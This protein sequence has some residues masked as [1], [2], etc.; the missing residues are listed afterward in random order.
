L[1]ADHVEEAGMA[2]TQ[3]A[4]LV[5]SGEGQTE[6]ILRAPG[7]WESRGVGN[8][9]L[10]TTT[11][12]DVIV[13]PGMLHDGERGRELFARVSQSPVR[14]IVLTQSHANQC[15]A[16]ELF[17]TDD[18]TLIAHREWPEGRAYASRLRQYYG[19]RSAKLWGS[20]TRMGSGKPPRD[21]PP[22][23]LIDDRFA[24]EL[25]GRRFEVI[26][27]PGGETRDA[28]V[29]WMPD[30][31]I[32]IVGNLFGPIFG[33]QPNLNTVRGDKPRWALQYI[34]SAKILRDLGADLVLTGHEAIEG[35]D[36]IRAGIT[37]LIESTQ[38]LHDRT[39]EGMN[40]GKDL[41][42]LMRE[43]RPPP[44]LVLGEGHGKVS[45]NVRAIWAEY[46]GWFDY[47]YTTSLYETP[48]SSVSGDLVALAG[49]AGPL[50]ARAKARLAAG[51]PVEAM[52]L[53]EVALEAEPANADAKAVKRDVLQ[54]LLD[55]AGGVN[56]SETMWLRS[57]L[58]A[59]DA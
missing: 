52:H 33:H 58:A 18:N 13:N 40:A 30:E 26:S 5:K 17:K 34:E 22:E 24:F 39:I 49:G 32:V 47:D 48:R 46:T 42:T 51:E 53:L 4:G 8:S 11:A 31:K 25:G 10:I 43:V 35:A 38:W 50:A 19:R 15:D 57:E 29:L 6:A 27:T 2:G 55:R 16:V 3:L 12:G 44:E 1:I 37:R 54:V 28:T 9:Y 41:H 59:L 21:F 23:V 7:V 56:L 20:I 14:Y 45:W 36:K